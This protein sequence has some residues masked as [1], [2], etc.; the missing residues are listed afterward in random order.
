MCGI[1]TAIRLLMQG[2]PKPRAAGVAGSGNPSLQPGWSRVC[3]SRNQFRQLMDYEIENP[4][5]L[6]CHG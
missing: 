3:G 2:A 4:V 6:E 5:A 1:A